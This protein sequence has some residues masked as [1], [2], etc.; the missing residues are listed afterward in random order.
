VPEYEAIFM[1]L[2]PYDPHLNTTNIKVNKFEFRMNP[3][4][5]DKVCIF[6]LA[7]T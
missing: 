5:I 2:F 7:C 3:T 1:E 4:I 6:M